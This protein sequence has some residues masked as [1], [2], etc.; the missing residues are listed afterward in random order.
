MA[1][2]PV[3]I[4]LRSPGNSGLR[5]S[6]PG[7][8]CMGL[9]HGCVPATERAQAITLIRT[10]VDRGVTFFDTAK[11]CGPYLNEDVAGEA[12]SPVRARVVIANRFGFSFGGDG[13]Q[14]IS[15]GTACP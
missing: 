9:G 3:D 6:A 11:V 10:A 13:K 8:G 5:V 1:T 2:N 15:G 7:L 14:Q 4:P 12:L